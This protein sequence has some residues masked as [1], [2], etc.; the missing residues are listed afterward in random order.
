MGTIPELRLKIKNGFEDFLGEWGVALIVAL[1]GLCA[2][3]L[4]RLSALEEN[5][6]AVSVREEP[7]QGR[8]GQGL[9]IGGLVVA[10]RGG[11]SYH[12]P[13]CAGADSILERN[14]LWFSSEEDARRAGYAP[15]RNCKGL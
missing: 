14:K 7:P 6:N 12:F 13:W 2:F 5:R 11:S 4:G 15:A 8:V 9:Q 10:S 1:V 3:G